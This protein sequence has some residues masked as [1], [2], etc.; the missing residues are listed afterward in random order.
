VVAN[1]VDNDPVEVAGLGDPG[2][3]LACRRPLWRD[4]MCPVA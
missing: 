2:A 3:T 1:L 4:G